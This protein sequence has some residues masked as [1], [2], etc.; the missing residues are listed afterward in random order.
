VLGIVRGHKG[1]LKVYSEPD[2]GST[3]RFLLPALDVAPA[4]AEAAQPDSQGWRGMGTVLVVDDEPEVREVAAR[5]LARFGFAVLLAE[6]GEAGVEL[7]RAN[8]SEIACVLL[9]M[10]MPR[11]NGEEAFRALRQIVPGVRVVLMSGYNEQDATSH[12]AGKGLAG[13]LAKP[14][15]PMDLR[16]RLQQALE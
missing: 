3:F 15:T 5:M 12:F 6:D 14:F 2:R 8:A 10:T 7:F 1:A 4:R 11:M 16:A 13:F 9:D